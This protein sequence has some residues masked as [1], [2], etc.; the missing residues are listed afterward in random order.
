MGESRSLLR[1]TNGHLEFNIFILT[2]MSYVTVRKY[3]F[4]TAQSFE[5]GDVYGRVANAHVLLFIWG[6]SFQQIFYDLIK[7]YKVRTLM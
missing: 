6:E 5:G 4:T 3:V 1:M 2:N 7:S